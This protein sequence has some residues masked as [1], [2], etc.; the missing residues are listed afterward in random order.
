MLR[1]PSEEQEPSIFFMSQIPHSD[2]SQPLA[3]FKSDHGEIF[4]YYEHPKSIGDIC[5]TIK[6]PYEYP[7]VIVVTRGPDAILIVRS[8]QNPS[9]TLF[10]CSLD[11]K[12]TH[13]NWGPI[14]PMSCDDFVKQARKIVT[15]IKNE[16]ASAAPKED[17]VSTLRHVAGSGIEDSRDWTQIKSVA[18]EE[19]GISTH[20]R[21]AASG[22]GQ[23]G[24]DL[25]KH[26]LQ[27]RKPTQAARAEHIPDQPTGAS[28]HKHDVRFAYALPNPGSQLLEYFKSDQG[29]GFY[30]YEHPKTLGG[31]NGFEPPY[32]YPQMIVILND[33]DDPFL[34]VRSEQN[35]S[36]TLFL[37]SLDTRGTHTN[38]GPISPM[39]RDDFV[40]EADKIVTQ[41]KNETAS[42]APEEDG[43][44]TLR[45]VAGSGI[46]DSRDRTQIKSVAPE[47]DGISTQGRAAASGP[48]YSRDKFMSKARRR[49]GAVI[50][51][52]VILGLGRAF[53]GIFS[54]AVHEFIFGP[55]P[56]ATEMM[57]KVVAEARPT[58]P[59]RLDDVT[60]LVAID[61]QGNRL[62]NS[63]I[64]EGYIPPN[65]IQLARI[66]AL[67]VCST[68]TAGWMFS[69]G[70][71]YDYFY[72]DSKRRYLGAATVS[73]DD[74]KG[75]A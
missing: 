45:H 12:G 19:D 2:H 4:S 11:A 18:L 17:A 6:S 72:W 7:Q 14:S 35:P 39:S 30:Y 34:I 63:L 43:V 56:T 66:Q 28:E 33:K 61:I 71:V 62:R 25:E 57:S 58:L 36:G 74:C 1:I 5:S 37:C 46:E 27:E 10:L 55:E 32:D 65:F 44:S 67:K 64:I 3:T 40:K 50:G 53:G 22:A 13:T 20:G 42:L 75:G 41:I 31:A 15:Q 52:L 23:I 47:E 49:V 16:T 24:S 21:A 54:S 29:E 73:K 51:L 68:K 38:W 69:R 59:K 48:E 60:T 8:E 26:I 70:V 9:G